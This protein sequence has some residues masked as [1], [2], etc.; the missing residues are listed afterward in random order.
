ML[1]ELGG[2]MDELSENLNKERV[3]IKKRHRNH[4]REPVRSEDHNI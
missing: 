4:K 3:G 2:K 1:K